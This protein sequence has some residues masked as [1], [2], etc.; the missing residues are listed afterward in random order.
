MPTAAERIVEFLAAQGID[1]AFC[2]PGE[3]YIALLDALHANNRMDLVTC[4][5]E[6]G[7]G[8]MA[9]ADAKL[10]GLPGVV[11]VSRGPGA[12]NAGIAVHTAEQDA[13]PLILL[14]GQVEKRDLRRNAFQEIDYANM[15]RGVAKWVGEA[16][17]PDQAPELI[18]RAFAMAMGGVP[19]PVVLSLPEDVLAMQCAAPALPATLPAPLAPAPADTARLAAL[20][21]TA[22]RPI[23]LAGHGFESAA[24]RAAL[25]GF[26]EAWQLP[27]AVSFRR[28]DLFPNSHPLY[29]GDLGLRNPDDQRA[30]FAE[31]DLVVAL[32]TRLT[33]ITTQGWSWPAAG[34]RLVHVCADPRFL[35]WLFPAELALAADA[36]A[37][38][39]ALAAHAPGAPAGRADWARRLHALHVADCQVAPGRFAD[40][41]AFAEVAKLIERVAPA[42][43][44]VTLDAGTF[45][46][47]FYRKT[48]WTPPQRLLAPVSGAMGFGVPAAVAAALRCPGRPVIGLVGDGGALMTGGELAVA[49]ARG[50]A[51]KLVLSDNGSYASIR[52]HQ[53]KAH[54][55]R[56][57]GTSLINP[58][59][60]QWC[61][62]FRVPV[63]QVESNADFP[64]LEA[65]LRTPG[66]AAIVVRTSLEAV[67]PRRL[68]A[69]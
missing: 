54:P 29:A 45:G 1:R 39:A 8:F 43:A 55:G 12:C 67:L 37:T 63:T 44:I 7:A 2:V 62:A 60:A 31:A 53:E 65:A 58:D 22:E 18:A 3:S 56:V 34:Q 21:R 48:A 6:G 11:L 28:Q 52:I 26:A 10:T 46:A 69:E 47:P 64:A 16:T 66:P 38:I 5:S 24:G 36:Q 13:V 17:D 14:V 25:Q 35:G 51:L 32:G 41:V 57:S 9:V 42:D 49:V 15:F 4:R 61:A 59:F 23:L 30:A 27:V 50:A 68:A 19:G 20:L 33:D 40:G